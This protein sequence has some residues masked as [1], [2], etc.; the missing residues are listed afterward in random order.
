MQRVLFQG[1]RACGV[2][3]SQGRRT[4]RLLAERVVICSGAVGSPALLQ[5]SGVGPGTLLSNL[6]LPVVQD[7]PGVGANLMDH[8]EIYLQQACTRPV[9]LKRHLSPL[10]KLNIGLQWL[11]TG[12]GLGA[13]NHFEVGGFVR[14]STAVDWPDIQFHFLPVAMAYDGSSFAPEHGFQVHVGPMLSP[15]RGNVSIV[16][17]DARQAPRIRFNYMSHAEDWR[18]FRSAIRQARNIFGQPA[19]AAYAGR[20][21]SPGAQ[22]ETD[23]ELDAF[24]A[25]NAQSAYHPCGTCK[26]GNDAMA[27]TTSA[28]QVHGLDGLYVADASLFPHITNGNLNA[29]TIMLAEKLSEGLRGA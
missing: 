29:P 23:A 10:G 13:T 24:V 12:R 16:S 18:V 2:E 20:E 8:L 21:L 15:S 11:T 27:V 17:A 25:A 5:R 1:R 14:S 26:M 28:G 9:S 22:A 4:R 6:D 7:L 19:L 3:V